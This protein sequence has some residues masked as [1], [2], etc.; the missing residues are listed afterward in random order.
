MILSEY[1]LLVTLG[2]KPAFL[3]DEDVGNVA[4]DNFDDY[5]DY[6][7]GLYAQTGVII[8]FYSFSYNNS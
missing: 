8:L 6:Y 7:N 1:L 5:Y 4:Y 3:Q 2:K